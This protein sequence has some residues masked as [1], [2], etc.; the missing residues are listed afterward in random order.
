MGQNTLFSVQPV[1]GKGNGVV[2]TAKITKGTRILAESPFITLPRVDDA[3]SAKSLNDDVLKQLRSVSRDQQRAFFSLTNI[4]GKHL[5]IPLGIVQ[6]NALA[7]GPG[8]EGGVFL[9]GSQ[10]NHA[11]LPSAISKWNRVLGKMTVH[12][13]CDI[14]PGEEITITYIQLETSNVRNTQLEGNFQFS[15]SCEICKLPEDMRKELDADIKD[16]KAIGDYL[17]SNNVPLEVGLW[18]AYRQRYLI[19]SN[20]LDQAHVPDTFD[21]A[22]KLAAVHKDFTRAKIFCERQLDIAMI[23]GGPDHPDTQAQQDMAGYFGSVLEHHLGPTVPH[24]FSRIQL[25]DWLWMLHL[26]DMPHGE[27]SEDGEQDAADGD[28]DNSSSDPDREVWS[29]D[30]DGNMAFNVEA[31]D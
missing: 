6:T 28:S 30:E 3:P 18:F 21:F 9:T 5:P 29:E 24:H 15:C 14:E 22:A 20:G 7:Y 17:K 19:E 27:S 11:C 10:F 16:I 12:A 1:A 8:S 23:E 4:H 2:A 13:L 25:E 26:P 31:L